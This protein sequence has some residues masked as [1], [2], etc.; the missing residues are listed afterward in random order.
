MPLPSRRFL[1]ASVMLV[2]TASVLLGLRQPPAER[3]ALVV[4]VTVD[5]LRPDY[6]SR[7]GG[8]WTGGFRR[9]LDAGA[10]FPNG[11]QD[12]ALTETAPGHATLLSGRDPARTG[13]FSNDF[14]VPDT[15]TRLIGIPGA[16][17]ASPHR[18]QGTT[19]VDWMKASDPA[20]GFLSVSQKDRSAILPI[21]RSVG[22]VY[23]FTDGRFTTSSY[24]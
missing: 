9:L 13:V 21:G 8:Q 14:G 17:G 19:L 24:Y 23:W 6:F 11:L 7:F 20:L 22:P 15:A 2:A 1:A 3:P 18:F 16:T 4:L 5:Q 10:V 12:H